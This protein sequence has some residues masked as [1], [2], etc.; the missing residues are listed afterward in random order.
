MT[1]EEVKDLAAFLQDDLKSCG[2][3]SCDLTVVEKILISLKTLG[4][5]S[6]QSS[7][8]RYDSTIYGTRTSL[9]EGTIPHFRINEEY[10]HAWL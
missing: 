9:Y 4:Y 1:K 3:R 5:G 2:K 7:S 6:F 10:S 8:K